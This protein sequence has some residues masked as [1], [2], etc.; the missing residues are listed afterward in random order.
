MTTDTEFEFY[1]ATRN[2]NTCCTIASLAQPRR[3]IVL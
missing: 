3:F 1:E 2:F